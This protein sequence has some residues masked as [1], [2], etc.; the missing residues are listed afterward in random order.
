MYILCYK[1][2]VRMFQE[3]DY[4]AWEL[5]DTVHF[6][7]KILNYVFYQANIYK[8]QKHHN[9]YTSFCIFHY[10]L[11]N[12]VYN[13]SI[14]QKSA[15]CRPTSAYSMI[16][17]L[18]QFIIIIFCCLSVKPKKFDTLVGLLYR[19]CL[20]LYTSLNIQ[21][22]NCVCMCVFKINYMNPWQ[23]FHS[24]HIFTDDKWAS[25]KSPGILYCTVFHRFAVV[26]NAATKHM[27]H[28]W[29]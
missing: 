2:H 24:N 28:C 20:L 7:R 26:Y 15:F 18:I 3:N 4:V 6:H 23:I 21:F 19:N 12:H 25:D 14:L 9:K 29:Q 22:Q 11:P 10:R 1:L 13:K 16:A 8:S 27:M 17:I 5:Q